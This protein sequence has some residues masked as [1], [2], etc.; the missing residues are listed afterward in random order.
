MLEAQSRAAALRETR[1]ALGEALAANEARA[2]ELTEVAPRMTVLSGRRAELLKELK[3]FGQQIGNEGYLKESARGDLRQIERAENADD[4]SPLQ[5]K[6]F[7][8]AAAASAVCTGALAVWTIVLGLWL[9]RVRGTKELAAHGDVE[10]LGSLPRRWALRKNAEKDALGVV[11]MNFVNAQAPKG[12]VLLCRL[13]GAKPQPK[14][15]SVLDW[16]LSMSGSRLFLLEVVQNADFDTVKGAETLLNTVRKGPAGW[17]PVVSRYSLAPTELQMLRADLETLKAEFDC[18]VVSMPGGLWKGGNF[19]SQLLGVCDSALLVTGF[20]KS[21]RRELRYV[22]RMALLAGKPM[23]GLVTG[24]GGRM[25][26]REME[27]S[28]W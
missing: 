3:D 8:L 19:L 11:A 21:R 18:I 2:A 15:V 12:V 26:R 5:P 10:V 14:F 1:A 16:S 7:V 9:G 22:R 23:M 13:K 25:V 6:N 24:A 28:K 4:R 20:D 17:F 27:A